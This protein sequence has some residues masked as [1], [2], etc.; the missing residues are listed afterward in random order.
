M[1]K[2]KIMVIDDEKIVV[3]MLGMHFKNNGY[4]VATFLAA[5]PALERLKEERFD[6]IITDLKMKGIDGMEL[7]K[8]VK[9]L[10]PD[11]HV[12]MITAYAQLNTAIEAFRGQVHDFY[13][14]P[15]K[16]KDLLASVERALAEQ[17]AARDAE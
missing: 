7:L 9:S 2:A 16:I 17:Q 12:I 1:G 14:K 15:F 6:V 5:E 11:V 4:D 3:D 10:Y 8:T 13:P